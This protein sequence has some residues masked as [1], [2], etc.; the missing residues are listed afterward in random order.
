MPPV[1][2]TYTDRQPL[3]FE[4]QKVSGVEYDA[5]TW[6]PENAEGLNF[7]RPVMRGSADRTCLLLTVAGAGKFLGHSVRDVSVRPSAGDK[8]PKGGNAT[9]LTKGAIFVRVVGAVNAGD[10]A[11]FDVAANRYTNDAPGAGV[12]ALPEGWEFD[13]AAAD[14]GIAPLIKRAK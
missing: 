14:G 6:I 2:E 1:Q 4:G 12:A 7:G 5:E 13:A 9:I 3:G 8:Y 11:N 10:Q